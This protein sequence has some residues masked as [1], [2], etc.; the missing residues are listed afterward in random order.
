MKEIILYTFIALV[1]VG[2]LSG[3]G[4]STHKIM[5]Q[6]D[7]PN[8]YPNGWVDLGLSVKWES[9]NLGVK[10]PEQAGELVR[11][12]IIGPLS[13]YET[14]DSITM[15]AGLD[16][17]E[18]GSGQV[19]TNLE[20]PAGWGLPTSDEFNELIEKCS[21]QWTE[22]DGIKGYRITSNVPGY[23]NRSIFLPAAGYRNPYNQEVIDDR[24][25]GAY[26]TGSRTDTESGCCL[27]FDST[28]QFVDNKHLSSGLCL[29]LV[30]N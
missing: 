18:S 15:F 21:W 13:E 2:F 26:W 3:I 29:R 16:N 17:T 30:C 8:H 28:R 11:W 1:Y 27:V 4:L 6:K 12:I 23:T 20:R 9:K 14:C 22:L 5:K 25:T 10:S 19:I 7:D 24:I